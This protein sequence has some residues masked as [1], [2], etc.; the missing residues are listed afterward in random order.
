MAKNDDIDKILKETIS[1]ILEI[2]IN[3]INEELHI[4]NTP[5]W[6]SLN[7]LRLI[8]EIEAKFSIQLKPEDINKM[9]DYTT[10]LHTL[11]N[12]IIMPKEE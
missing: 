1:N 9:I 8:V 3:D 2:N 5:N 6:S 11:V 4:D 12:S 10:I 7:H